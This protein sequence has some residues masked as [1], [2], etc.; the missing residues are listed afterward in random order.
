MRALIQRVSEA[1]VTVEDRVTGAIEKGFL[2]LL[3]I[4]HEDGE[5]D[6]A[7]LVKKISQLRIFTDE[8]GKMNRSIQDVGGDVLVIS[9]FTLFGNAKKGNRPSFV[10]SARP[11]IAIPLYE[12]FLQR[13][14]HAF[15]GKVATGEF[16]AMMQVSLVNEGPVTLML[17]SKERGY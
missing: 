1:Q 7:W 12:Q 14:D 2:I 6:I 9:Q 8:E 3:G 4:T 15:D 17:D 10:R 11:D 13:L 16:G 5:E